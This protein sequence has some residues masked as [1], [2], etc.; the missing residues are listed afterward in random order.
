MSRSVLSLPAPLI[1]GLAALG[2]WITVLPLAAQADVVVHD[3][4]VNRDRAAREAV[5]ARTDRP[6]HLILSSDVLAG[7]SRMLV[8]NASIERCEG[9]PVNFDVHRKLDQ[10]TDKVLAFDLHEARSALAVVDTLLPCSS[11]PVNKNTLARFAFL[12]GAT[13]LDLGEK[14]AAEAAM[15]K[16]A[17][18]D[19]SYVGERGF[20][21]PHID[22]LKVQAEFVSSLQPG[23]LFIW[24]EPGAS[25]LFINGT[26]AERIHDRG[27][28]IKPGTHLLQIV[29][30]TGMNGLWVTTKGSASSLVFPSSGR[31]VWADGGR[32]PGGEKAMHL[33]L[34]DEFHGREG[35]VHTIHYQGRRG[36]GSTYPWNG[37]PRVSWK[38]ESDSKNTR[39]TRPSTGKKST[40]KASAGKGGGKKDPGTKRPSKTKANR[41]DRPQPRP[42]GSSSET[43]AQAEDSKAPA[44]SESATTVNLD[45]PVVVE[46]DDSPPPAVSEADDPPPPAVSTAPA[47]ADEPKQG[48]PTEQANAPGWV[49]ASSFDTEDEEDEDEEDEDEEVQDSLDSPAGKT[50]KTQ[51]PPSKTQSPPPKTRKVPTKSVTTVD[52]KPTRLRIVL[53]GG[54][55]YAEPFHYAMLKFD[56]SVRIVG[57]VEVNAFVR[58]SYGGVHQFPVEDGATPLEGPVIFIPFGVSVGIRKPG[59][60]SPWVAGGGQVAWNRDGLA[61]A[62]YLFGAVLHGG[63]DWSP[64][65]SRFVIRI[66]GELGNIGT[67]LNVSASGGVGLRF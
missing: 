51:S 62:P 17:G 47:K 58:P 59:D 26:Q 48:E 38:D 46:A 54:Y 22:L 45:T 28:L 18:F 65:G 14:D 31:A 67:H 21:G 35:D 19:P 12:K 23:R 16:A 32:S 43:I 39:K 5:T 63:L 60:L 34:Q 10:I 11:R 20:P 6:P 37:G 41:K 33:L 7:P 52:T 29:S 8:A 24:A 50:T 9:R 30:S 61:A 49:D 36:Y 40:G 56:L 57:I 3:G 1:A 2:L 55:Q 15:K 13:L 64:K 53:S 25:D 44:D 66:Q 27:I 4:G 42:S